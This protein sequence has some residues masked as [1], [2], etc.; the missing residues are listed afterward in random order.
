MVLEGGIV[1]MLFLGGVQLSFWSCFYSAQM[2][3]PT[4]ASH[5]HV[6]KNW[7]DTHVRPLSTESSSGSGPVC[8]KLR[9]G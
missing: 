1:D 8:D 9:I 2:A 4:N 7:L 5:N 6:G 3:S